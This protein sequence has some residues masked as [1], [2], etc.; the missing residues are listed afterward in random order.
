[1]KEQWYSFVC[2][3]QKVSGFL[4]QTVKGLLSPSMDPNRSSVWAIYLRP[5]FSIFWCM[6]AYLRLWANIIFSEDSLFI[7]RKNKLG[8]ASRSCLF[9]EPYYKSSLFGKPHQV[10]GVG[11]IA[12]Y[13]KEPAFTHLEIIKHSINLVFFICCMYLIVG[14]WFPTHQ[15]FNHVRIKGPGLGELPFH[16]LVKTKQNWQGLC[17][18][19]S[20]FC[21]R[22]D[23][24]WQWSHG[25]ECGL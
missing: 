1:M 8:P 24:G 14:V 13:N 15:N 9:S 22:Q 21:R 6:S 16:G 7:S 20:Q 23:R 2:S 4:M 3:F 10:P 25:P 19:R 17:V 5:I 11:F 12:I 18:N